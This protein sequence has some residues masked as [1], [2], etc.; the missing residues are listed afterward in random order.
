MFLHQNTV[1]EE[2]NLCS[3]YT[4]VTFFDV[5]LYITITLGYES[6]FM[7][8]REMILES[9]MNEYFPLTTDYIAIIFD[10]ILSG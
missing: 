6:H 4:S 9:G 7:A 1:E 8:S 5:S 3:L 10:M 2:A